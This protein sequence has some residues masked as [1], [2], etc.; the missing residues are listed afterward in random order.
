[1]LAAVTWRARARSAACRAPR[2]QLPRAPWTWPRYCSCPSA[3]PSR[4]GWPTR[5]ALL[6]TSVGVCCSLYLGFFA[7][8]I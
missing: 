3:F 7:S 4:V 8:C 2:E 6:K 1:M 5:P